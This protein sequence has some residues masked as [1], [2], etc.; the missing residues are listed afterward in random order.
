VM[1]VDAGGQIARPAITRQSTRAR[2][3]ERRAVAFSF[4]HEKNLLRTAS[5][6]KQTAY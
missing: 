2:P 1:T 5:N 6:S 3:Y 4:T